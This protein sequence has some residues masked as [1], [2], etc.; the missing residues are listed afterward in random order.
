M[1]AQAQNGFAMR[2]IVLIVG[3]A[4]ASPAL[5]AELWEGVFTPLNPDEYAKSKASGGCQMD[6]VIDIV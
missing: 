2:V 6:L 4:L 1:P 5:A 3:L